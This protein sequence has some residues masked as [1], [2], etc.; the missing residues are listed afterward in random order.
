MALS[1]NNLQKSVEG[2]NQKNLWD[3]EGE[4]PEKCWSAQNFVKNEGCVQLW[5]VEYRVDKN[6]FIICPIFWRY[7]LVYFSSLVCVSSMMV[8]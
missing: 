2:K 4:L 7:K 1:Y 5:A 6:Y 8:V 3:V